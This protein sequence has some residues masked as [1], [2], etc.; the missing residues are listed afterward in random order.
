MG[1]GVRVCPFLFFG[2]APR[3]SSVDYFPLLR[4]G[5]VEYGWTALLEG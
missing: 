5:C 3:L 2:F 4:L 1:F